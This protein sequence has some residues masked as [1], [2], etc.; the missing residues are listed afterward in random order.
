MSPSCMG[1]WCVRRYTC[2]LHQAEDRGLPI[3]RLCEHGK[4]DAYVPVRW[5][6]VPQRGES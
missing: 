5:V 4:T 1:G 6:I 3:E 2:A